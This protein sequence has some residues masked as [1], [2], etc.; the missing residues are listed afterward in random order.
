DQYRKI[1]NYDLML[2]MR[3]TSTTQLIGYGYGKRFL[4][5]GGNLDMIKDIY[6]WYNLLPH[7]QILWVWMRLGTLGF[8]AFWGMICA[9]LVYAC[10]VIRYKESE[11]KHN[12]TASARSLYPR[13]VA[14]YTL[15]LVAL[16]LVFGLLDLQLSNFR[17]MI[18]VAIWVGAM[19]GL[20]PN[21]LS[22]NDPEKR[23]CRPGVHERPTPHER[24]TRQPRRMS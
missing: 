4:T 9:I 17:D 15:I 14:L 13:A 23:R 6:P 8:L 11:T 24:L 19:S 5:P 12:K 2:T 21:A 1:E 18:F 20:T 10:R 22:L 7:N 3:S 16:L